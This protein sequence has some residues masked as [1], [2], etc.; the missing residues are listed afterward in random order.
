MELK[1]LPSNILDEDERYAIYLAIDKLNSIRM[2]GVDQRQIDNL[3]VLMNGLN[4]LWHE[5]I[6]RKGRKK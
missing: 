1:N 6:K 3:N 4:K 2:Y 5:R